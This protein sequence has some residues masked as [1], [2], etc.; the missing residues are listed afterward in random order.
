MN[1]HE[2]VCPHC[3]KAFKVDESGY[4]EILKQVHD[5]DFKKQLDERIEALEQKNNLAKENAVL[6]ATSDLEKERL[7]L[8]ASLAS[9]ETEKRLAVV[10]ALNE[11]KE[12]KKTAE[13]NLKQQYETQLRER[14][15]TI[16]DLRNLKVRL[17]TKMVGETLEQH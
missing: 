8:L 16:K 7:R 14:E 1:M 9:A 11:V 4:A 17:S 15:E 6:K 5:K 12:D 10:T 13:A 3:E 2:I